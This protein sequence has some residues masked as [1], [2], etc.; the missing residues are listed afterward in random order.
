MNFMSASRRNAGS[1]ITLLALFASLSLTGCS[2]QELVLGGPA[3]PLSQVS[4]LPKPVSDDSNG[5]PAGFRLGADDLISVSVFGLPDAGVEKVR[6]D[7]SGRVSLPLA[8]VIQAGGLTLEEL[9]AELS[10]RLRRAHVRDPKVAIALLEIE[11]ARL[12][13]EGQ[14]AKPGVYSAL[15]NMTLLQA[16][17]S[18]QG[19][20]ETA[21]LQEVV[22]FR[23]VEGQK[24]AALYDIKAIR[25]GA[26]PDPMIFANDTVVVGDSEARRLFR[27]F[28]QLI[29]L[30]TTPI[31]VAL[32][33]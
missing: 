18:A 8:G 31:I 15:P 10:S 13:V 1:T 5:N 25:K 21:R 17:A 33:N 26:Y 3:N 24:Y 2:R 32:Q 6:I 14:V 29:P 11:S 27:D 7:R 19:V 23:T 12:T 4:E 30:I 22:V 28:I 20:T 16:I 9:T